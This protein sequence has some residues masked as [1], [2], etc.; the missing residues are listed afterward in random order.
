MVKKKEKVKPAYSLFSNVIYMLR[1]QWKHSRML[2][3]FLTA[4]IPLS[5]GISFCNIYLPKLVVFEVTNGKSVSHM[6]LAVGA[7]GLIVAALNSFN[8][9]ID[10]Y[11][12]IASYEFVDSVNFTRV[13]KLL[14]TDYEN[15]TESKYRLL[16][17]RAN[18]LF[19]TSRDVSPITHM[20]K[21]ISGFAT[22]IIGY[23]LFGT[24]ISSA[25]PWIA[26][27]LTFTAM[28]NYFV[29]RAIQNYQ[30][31]HRNDTSMIER[32]MW[33]LSKNSGAFDSAKDIRIYGMN[34]W[35]GNMYKALA[36]EHLKWDK[37]FAGRYYI[38]NIIDAL[39]ILLRDGF[40]YAVL[41]YMVI[42]NRIQIDEFV[43]CIGAV[44]S[45]AGW[46]GGIFNEIISINKAS[47][48]VCDFRD[49][50]SYPEKNNRGRGC[51]LQDF[52]KPCEIELKNVSY[53]Y[54]GTEN[55]ILTDISLK[56]GAGEKIAIVGL[57]GAGKTTLIKNICGLYN[58]TEGSIS[59]NGHDRNEYN[60]Y[61]Y[62][63]MFAIVFQDFHFLPVSIATTVSSETYEHTDRVKVAEC[64]RLA[65]LDSKINT[66]DKGI[67]TMLNKQLN[68][69][70][71]ELSG[72]EKQKLLLARAIYKDAPVLILDEPTSAL[73]PIAESELYEK[74]H[75]LM[76]NKTSIYISH[77]LAS[78]RFCDRIL[79]MEDGRIIETG[80]HDELMKQ[81]SK[82]AYLF[83]VQSHYYKEKEEA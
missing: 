37:K 41:I 65:G 46:I 44:G 39:M 72:G 10:T 18:E 28:I 56:I 71:V 67:D 26:V 40:A 4:L 29:V 77:R 30:Y 75:E 35:F 24:I 45:F 16:F 70:G 57:N 58:P 5:L 79:Y 78:T 2:L 13:Q 27:L 61:D 63:S 7:F 66:L 23:I 73:D 33:Y 54:E 15:T 14:N 69:G 25:S 76:K 53:R 81:D 9:F 62:Y 8:R 50:L 74:Y 60:I 22:N 20:P 59:V 80:T 42:N 38:S 6:I 49:Y 32:K 12:T 68:E 51:P 17:Q 43:L 21:G 82:Y 19:W 64:I 3:M 1:L 34:V 55:D 47:L 36:K 48:S 11:T 83:N 31:R 52:N